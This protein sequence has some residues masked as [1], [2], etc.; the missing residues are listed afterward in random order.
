MTLGIPHP[1][2]SENIIQSRCAFHK[3]KYFISRPPF[4]RL[5][6]IL[7]PHNPMLV[8]HSTQSAAHATLKR[9]R[10]TQYIVSSSLYVVPDSSVFRWDVKQKRCSQI[11]ESGQM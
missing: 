6:V 9:T 3:N 5:H 2:Q 4:V 11:A 1:I 7:A 10:L 8:T